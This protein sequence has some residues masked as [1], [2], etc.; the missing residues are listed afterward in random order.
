M[1]GAT[2][3][4]IA[5]ASV[6]SG[7]GSFQTV[8]TEAFRLLHTWWV[9]PIVLPGVSMVALAGCALLMRMKK[10]SHAVSSLST[11]SYFLSGPATAIYAVATSAA[12]PPSPV[13][14]G[15]VQFLLIFSSAWLYLKATGAPEE[16]N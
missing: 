3:V 14:T 9:V 1:N 5:F 6:A 7:Y 15:S 12:G 11:I 16:G 4:E 10:K 2:G 8:E 13:W